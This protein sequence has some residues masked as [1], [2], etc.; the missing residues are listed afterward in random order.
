MSYDESVD[1]TEEIVRVPIYGIDSDFG[2]VP[3]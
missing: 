1:E 3:Y 2:D